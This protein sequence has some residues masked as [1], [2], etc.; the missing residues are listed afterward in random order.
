MDGIDKLT[1]DLGGRPLLRWSVEAMAAASSV[2]RIIVVTAPDRVAAVS[3]LPWLRA[4]DVR[5]V[6]GGI[7]R[8]DSVAAGVR[9]A[10]SEVVLVHDGARPLVTPALVDAVAAAAAAGGAAI[11]VLR[12]VDSLK[13]L[14]GDVI[15]GVTPRDGL[16]RAQTPQG[17]RRELLLDA[18]SAFAATEETYGDEAELLAR[19]GVRVT[20]V[21]GESANLKV[22]EPADLA[23]ARTLAAGRAAVPRYATGWDSHP[24]GPADGLRLCGIE[25]PDAPRLHG[26]SDGDVAL[27]AVCDALLA[28]TAQGDLGRLFPAGDPETRGIDSRDLVR[29]VVGR[30]GAAGWRPASADVTITGARPHL[31]GA[32]LDRMRVALAGLLDVDP[33]SVGVKAATGNLLGDTG[34]GRAIAAAALVGVVGA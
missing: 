3:E 19:N 14:E 5:V 34:A 30:I 13:R 22:T 29:V 12:V 21:P 17:A 16:G 25:I 9:E 32:R 33:A 27:H 31:G 20:S 8:Q 1:A 4:L 7:R 23:L 10:R 15:V 2:D 28:A 24:F 26:H 6:P 18:I 11:P